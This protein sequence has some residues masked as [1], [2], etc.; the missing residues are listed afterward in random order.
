MR[1][2]NVLDEKPKLLPLF[3]LLY[4]DIGISKEYCF[5]NSL[6]L[7][8]SRACLLSLSLEFKLFELS[9][10]SLENAVCFKNLS[11]GFSDFM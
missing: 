7:G 4:L 8:R 3:S 6:T 5:D 11:S 1:L 2:D 10:S 9:A